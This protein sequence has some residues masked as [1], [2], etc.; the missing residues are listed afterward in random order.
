LANRISISSFVIMP[1]T[2]K[3]LPEGILVVKG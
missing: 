3:T 1:P 2:I